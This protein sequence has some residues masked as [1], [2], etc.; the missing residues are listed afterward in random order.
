MIIIS[1]KANTACVARF[2]S[3]PNI[4]YLSIIPDH[5]SRI[6]SKDRIS[7]ASL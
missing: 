6:M 5:G 1:F 4:P 2:I 3:S 7:A